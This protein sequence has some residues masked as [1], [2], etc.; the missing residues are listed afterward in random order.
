MDRPKSNRFLVV[1]LIAGALGAGTAIVNAL[2]APEIPAPDIH[3]SLVRFWRDHGG[4][5][6][7]GPPLGT[8][9]SDGSTLRQLFLN[10]EIVFDA[11][12]PESEGTYLSNLGVSLGLA[13]PP[14]HRPDDEEALY[15]S[16]T[17]HTMYTGFVQAYELLGGLDFAGAP[18]SEVKFQ[19][20]IILQMFENLGLFRAEDDPPSKVKLLS[21]GL[22]VSP[23]SIS[24]LDAEATYTLPPNIRPRPFA[25][26][27]DRYGGESLFGRPL[28][29]PYVSA[30]GAIEQVYERAILYSPDYDPDNVR[31]RPINEATSPAQAPVPPAEDPDVIYSAITGHNIRWAF[32]RFYRANQGEKL[33]G[34]PLEEARLVDDRLVQRFQN[35]T[36]E[37]DQSLPAHLAVQ[38][39]TLSQD[40]LPS[41]VFA[42]AP[43]APPTLAPKVDPVDRWS[44]IMAS[45]V[46]WV[47]R[48]ILPIG[49]PQRI[50]IQVARGDGSSWAGVIPLIAIHTQ[51]ADIFPTAVPTDANG[52]I[53]LTVRFEDL[54]PGEIVNYEV[55]V[56]AEQA[57]G[58][59]MGQFIAHPRPID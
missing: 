3:P 50:H 48:P 20:G 8:P 33:L 14:V 28:T 46:T 43:S 39:S 12:D 57:I 59:A 56:A 41:A 27:L 36:L 5:G 4:E 34:L 58:Y 19:G 37:Y 55:A 44:P 26:Y 11:D 45:V 6:T 17:G 54:Q 53:A 49:E 15:Y 24:E 31:L 32:A 18:I 21:L 52:E 42:P 22:A 16:S 23:E 47:E 9:V 25:A 30:D 29:G 13:E 40:V 1:I 10:A 51:A 2:Q 35:G 38:L 7:F